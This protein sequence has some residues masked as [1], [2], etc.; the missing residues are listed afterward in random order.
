MAEHINTK[1]YDR[2]H[3]PTSLWFSQECS[4]W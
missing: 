4:Y 1:G 3:Y 2:N